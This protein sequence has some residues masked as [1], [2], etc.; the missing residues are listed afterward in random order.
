MWLSQ[1]HTYPVVQMKII[2]SGD[3]DGFIVLPLLPTKISS[4]AS[5]YEESQTMKYTQTYLNQDAI[6]LQLWNFDLMLSQFTLYLCIDYTWV[7]VLIFQ[8]HSSI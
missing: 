4:R 8:V 2:C 1:N 3:W 7:P 5:A 6:T